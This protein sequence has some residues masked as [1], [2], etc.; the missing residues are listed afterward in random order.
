M[1]NQQMEL[2]NLVAETSALLKEP[3][4]LRKSKESLKQ[5][6]EYLQKNEDKIVSK[7]N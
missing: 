1:K 7:N 2:I 3:I 4:T 5:L 6:D